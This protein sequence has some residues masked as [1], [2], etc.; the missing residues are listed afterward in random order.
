MGKNCQFCSF[1]TRDR[2]NSNPTAGFMRR[3][4]IAAR[5]ALKPCSNYIGD[6]DTADQHQHHRH[7][8]E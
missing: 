5:E 2:D 3:I 4:V 8:Q 1:S 6:K 7:G